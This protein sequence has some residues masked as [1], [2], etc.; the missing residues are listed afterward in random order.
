MDS[1][2]QCGLR[3]CEMASG[4]YVANEPKMGWLAAR[5]APDPGETSRVAYR[6]SMVRS[7]RRGEGAGG[8]TAPSSSSSALSRLPAS[9]LISHACAVLWMPPRSSCCCNC[10][11]GG[12]Q[13]AILISR[14]T[15]LFL[16][17][18][19][20]PIDRQYSPKAVIQRPTRLRIWGPQLPPRSRSR[21]WCP[22]GGDV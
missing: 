18:R 22:S 11:Y 3:Q 15:L 12:Y 9:P 6:C 16:L 13:T 7:R 2:R 19:I 4:L 20:L 8:E 21:T 1:A 17:Q 5:D 10:N 14:R